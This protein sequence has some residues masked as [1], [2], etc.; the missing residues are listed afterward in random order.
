[1]R[2]PRHATR[3]AL[4]ALLALPLAI[5][6]CAKKP[7]PTP[8]PVLS[9]AELACVTRA[10]EASGLDASTITVAP[11][12]STKTGDTIYTVTAGGVDYTCVVAP[13]MTVSQ[14]AAQ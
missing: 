10:A 6:A 4:A 2:K 9:G 5:G 13:D 1:M 7:E 8:V 14:F 11:T 12:A 3:I